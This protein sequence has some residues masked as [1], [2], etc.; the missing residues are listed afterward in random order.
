[1]A[2]QLPE[3]GQVFLDH[4]AHFVP[5]M[6]EATQVLERCGFLLTPFTQ[7]TNREGGKPVSAGTANR[8][9]MFKRGYLEILAATADTPLARQLTERLGHHIGLHLAAF[10]TADA[11]SERKRL[12]DAGFQV[13]PLV[14]MRRPVMAG[15]GE[16]WARFTIAR[17][18]S[19]LMP[20]GRMQFL[21]HHT[22]KLVWRETFL[23]H[24]NG[25]QALAA[26]WVAAA[27]PTGS[28]A[29]FGRF[30]GRPIHQQ[31]DVLTIAL[32]RGAVRITTPEF[33]KHE[34]GIEPGP[35]LPYLAAC[36]IEIMGIPRL[37]E[38]LGSA[39]LPPVALREGI[40][41]SLPPSIGGTIV[42]REAAA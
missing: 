41:L 6:G 8:C 2:G 30:I 7:Q 13:L 17:I 25:A 3:L 15:T 20:E 4:V 42:F 39:G 11:A 26:V 33:L 36:E 27:D 9:A 29:R 34:F 18:A 5:A 1:M 35:R 28:A 12:A 40:A 31:G 37:I 32:D 14:D 21:T 38:H 22:E 23:D 10:S 16:D 19:G 24:P